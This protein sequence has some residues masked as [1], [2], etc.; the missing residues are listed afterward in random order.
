MPWPVLLIDFD[1]PAE[2]LVIMARLGAGP[3]LLGVDNRGA[4]I[5]TLIPL[6]VDLYNKFLSD[7]AGGILRNVFLE[8]GVSVLATHR[9]RPE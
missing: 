8:E 7:I 2:S 1:I 5:Q 9:L 3:Q 4:T 6:E